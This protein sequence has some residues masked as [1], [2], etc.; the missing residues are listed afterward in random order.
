M[1]QR[2]TA[3]PSSPANA[4]RTCRETTSQVRFE[5][6]SWIVSPTQMMGW[7]F[8]S[9][10]AR[11]LR[12]T[13]SS[14]SPK[15][16]RRSLWP[17]ITPSQPISASM[18]ALTSPVNAPCFSWWQ[19]CPKSWM[20]DPCRACFT[21]ASAVNGGATPTCAPAPS[22]FCRS[23][24][25]SCTASPAVLCI[26]QLPQMNLRLLIEDLHAGKLAAL[27]KLQ[28]RAPPG[29]DVRHLV[30]EAHLHD[31]G[32]AVAATHH[33]RGASRR[34]L[35]QRLGHRAR[36]GG[37]LR[38]LEHPHRPVPEHRGGARD[39]LLVLG[40]GLGTDVEPDP[41]VRDGIVHDP[42]LDPA[43]RLSRHHVVDR[44]DQLHPGPPRLSEHPPRPVQL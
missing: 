31:R 24:R 27:E 17:R 20:A 23:S 10:T 22:S 41:A 29:R 30:G 11:S 35:G 1:V 42:R 40:D 44:Q 9:R 37:V 2:P 26:F 13:L 5:S 34:R 15:Y 33:R 38:R 43:L 7:S 25:T 32:R 4:P 14:V 36:S 21:A 19:F 12:L 16:C 28:R 6:R 8:A 3:S 18:G 39:A